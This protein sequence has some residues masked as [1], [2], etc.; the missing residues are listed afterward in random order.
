MVQIGFGDD[1]KI[2]HSWEQGD[3]QKELSTEEYVLVKG[4][5]M[6]EDYEKLSIMVEKINELQISLEGLAQGN[7]SL[8]SYE[9]LF[10][11]LKEQNLLVNNVLIKCFKNIL[12]NLYSDRLVMKIHPFSKN[13]NLN[14]MSILNRNFLRDSIDNITF[15]YGACPIKEWYM[16]GKV[17]TIFPKAYIPFEVNDLKKNVILKNMQVISNIINF[18]VNFEDLTNEIK[19]LWNDLG[20]NE[21]DFYQLKKDNLEN[22]FEILFKSI[23]DIYMESNPKFP[24][25]SLIPIAIYTV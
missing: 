8:K 18:H 19:I 15:N 4:R 6:I 14:F 7:E 10:Y 9:D 12:N 24:S 13:L 3:L 22:Q 20:L 2:K 23:N 5:V 21:D 16:L 25:V 1:E 17:A 11:S